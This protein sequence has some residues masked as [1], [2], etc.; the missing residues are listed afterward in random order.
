MPEGDQ[1]MLGDATRVRARETQFL[2]REW[3]R[4]ELRERYDATLDSPLPEELVRLLPCNRNTQY[5][6]A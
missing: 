1:T 3:L 5:R 2:V 6:C 4:H